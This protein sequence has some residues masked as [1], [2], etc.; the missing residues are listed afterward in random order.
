MPRFIVGAFEL[1]HVVHSGAGGE[2]GSWADLIVILRECSAFVATRQASIPLGGFLIRLKFKTEAKIEL[3]IQ[4][5][6]LRVAPVKVRFGSIRRI[7]ASF[8]SVD[9]VLAPFTLVL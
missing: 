9:E 5:A 1:I 3:K 4:A 7:Y 6:S 2:R 8:R